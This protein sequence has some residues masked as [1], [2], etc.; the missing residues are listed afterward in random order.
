M[1][2]HLPVPNWLLSIVFFLAGG[3]W[4]IVDKL[5]QNTPWTQ[6]LQPWFIFIFAG[7]AFTQLISFWVTGKGPSEIGVRRK[8]VSEETNKDQ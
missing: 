4:A 3:T 2:I 7:G 8:A 5:A 6:L 1:K